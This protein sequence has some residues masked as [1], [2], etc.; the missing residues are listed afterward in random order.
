M[1]SGRKLCR[2]NGISFICGF[3]LFSCDQ[4]K[5]WLPEGPHSELI[6]ARSLR[7]AKSCC[8]CGS[9]FA[10]DAAQ[11]PTKKAEHGAAIL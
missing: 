9:W 8:Y 6:V 5:L 11:I 3:Q 7:H 2:A 1:R 4:I 10:L